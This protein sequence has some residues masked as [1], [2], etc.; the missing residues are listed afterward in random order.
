MPTPPRPP[1][2]EARGTR[3]LGKKV[4]AEIKFI[5]ADGKRIV[6]HQ[7]QRIQ[8][9]LGTGLVKLRVLR[10]LIH[11]AAGNIRAGIDQQRIGIL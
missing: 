10:I 7:G 8:V 1:Q 6:P 9:D 3:P 5:I 11:E 4:P 2:R